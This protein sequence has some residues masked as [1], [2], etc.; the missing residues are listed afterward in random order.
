MKFVHAKGIVFE[1]PGK[2]MSKYIFSRYNQI[3]SVSNLGNP[4]AWTPSHIKVLLTMVANV[5]PV[6]HAKKT[7]DH[8]LNDRR[9][10]ASG[11][12]LPWAA[13]D[14]FNFFTLT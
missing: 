12:H 13:A 7:G 4:I 5:A 3:F 6:T 9:I 2:I 8:C 1:Y 11:S 14:A 10:S